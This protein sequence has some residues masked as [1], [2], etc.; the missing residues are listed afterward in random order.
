V[1]R[2]RVRQLPERGAGGNRRPPYA[3][4]RNL[5]KWVLANLSKVNGQLL[6]RGTSVGDLDARELCDVAYSLL[7]EDVERHYYAQVAAGSTW[8][9]VSDPLGDAIA[10]LQERLG[11]REDPEAVALELHKG[12]LA[13]RGIEWDDTP[14]GG[15]SGQ[16]W[17]QEAEFTVMG[18]LDAAARRRAARGG[19]GNG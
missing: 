1:R 5:L 10:R 13:A 11:L 2:Q 14:V 3:G 6:R 16:W 9:D 12:L 4:A 15:G 17:D 7:A 18:D 8:K 19:K